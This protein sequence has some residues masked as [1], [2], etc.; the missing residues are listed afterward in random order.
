M[1]CSVLR[2]C[3]VHEVHRQALEVCITSPRCVRLV[4]EFQLV[5]ALAARCRSVL[6]LPLAYYDG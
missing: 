2:F 1:T 3:C 5:Q 4:L 6:L